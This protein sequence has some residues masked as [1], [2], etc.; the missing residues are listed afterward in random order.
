MMDRETVTLAPYAEE[1]FPLSDTW[2]ITARTRGVT[3]QQLVAEALFEPTTLRV[4]DV[5]GKAGAPSTRAPVVA[6]PGHQWGGH[7][8]PARSDVMIIGKMPG[9]AE[10]VAR[11]NFVGEGG[12]LLNKTFHDAG[13]NTNA[14]YTTNVLRFIPPGQKKPKVA[15]HHLRDCATLLMHEIL[16]VNPK[17]ILLLGTDA[18]KFLFGRKATLSSM[19]GAVMPYVV[20]QTGQ[21]AKL[22]HNKDLA[23]FNAEYGKKVMATI[24]P[25]QAVFD[26]A[27]IPS[28]KDDVQ[29]FCDLVVGKR[30]AH[31]ISPADT[32]DYRYIKCVTE[33]KPIVDDL[34]ARGITEFSVD[35]EWGGTDYK[36]GWL[37]TIQFSWAPG[38]AVVIVLRTAE[39]QRKPVFEPTPFHAL[40]QLHR[41]LDRDGVHI[42]G[43]YFRSDALWLEDLGLRVMPRLAFDTMLA[44]HALNESQEYNLTALALRHTNM[45]RYDIELVNWL[46]HNK[47]EDGGYGA[48]PDEILHPYGAADADA[49]FRITA[50]LRKELDKPE[51]A[52]IRQLYYD[53]IL[54]ASQPIHDMERNGITLDTNR[55]IDLLWQY[56]DRK[57]ELLTEIRQQ[58]SWDDF[59]PRS[60]VQKA[61]LLYGDPADGGLGLMPVKSTEKPSRE[62]SAVLQL[63][64]AERARVNP[65]TDSES[66]ELLHMNAVNDYQRAV[67]ESVQNFQIIDQVTKN[68]LRPPDGATAL[69]SAADFDVTDYQEGLLG[70]MDGDGRVRTTISQTKETGRHGSSRPNMQNLSKRQEPKYQAIMGYKIPKIRSCFVARPGYV[71]VEAD[72]KSAEIVTLAYVS[73][74]PNLIA[75]ALGPVKLHSKVAVDILGADCDYSEV[76]EKFPHL[77]VGAKNINFG[78]PYQRGARAIARQVNRETKGAADMTQD[79][80]QEIIDAWYDRYSKVR[81]YV[82]W[83][84]RCVRDAPHFIQTPWGRRRHF[85]LSDN[86]SVMAAQERECVNFPIQGTVADALNTGLYNLWAYRRQHPEYNY[87]LLLAIH[88]A[89]ILEVPIEIVEDV[90]DHILPLCMVHGAQIPASDRSPAF[91]LGIDTEIMFRWGEDPTLEEAKQSGLAERFWPKSE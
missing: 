11:R 46:K 41:L 66:L 73:G 29:E 31:F 86:E 32:N 52:A 64:P 67:V 38:K 69:H 63:P 4:I 83:C 20:S 62:W 79:Q 48:V 77:Y 25:G 10:L 21:L 91:N 26:P 80:A 47:C 51:N 30:S 34:I 89:V 17:Y 90:V 59:N 82:A 49:V 22:E 37:R 76:S 24:H 27:L 75:D 53:V 39:S 14:I 85:Y 5:K 54:P 1:L 19:R 65:S 87:E 57:Q 43:Q 12:R 2:E 84:K 58:T 8:G 6:L 55:M 70:H 15:A 71:L 56:H 74:D 13:M 60:T 28:L 33:L 50:V 88:D 3:I 9:E 40:D 78:I 42:Y 44:S 23:I 18:I 16:A 72:Y 7:Y 81:D 35:C 61:K 36:N 68:F 45:G